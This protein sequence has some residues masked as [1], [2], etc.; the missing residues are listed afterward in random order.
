MRRTFGFGIAV[1]SLVLAFA[2]AHPAQTCPDNYDSYTV[3]GDVNLGWGTEGGDLWH[4]VLKETDTSTA[5]GYDGTYTRGVL[6]RPPTTEDLPNPLNPTNHNWTEVDYL[7]ATGRHGDRALY[8]L[9][10]LDPRFGNQPVSLTANRFG[11]GF[12]L[13]GAGRSIRDVSHIDVVHSFTTI[14]SVPKDVHPYSPMLVVSGAGITPKS[15]GPAD[16]Q[17]MAQVTFDA[18]ASTSNTVGIWTGP[19]LLGVLRASGVNTEDMDSYIVVQATDGYAT[20]VSMYEA[21]QLI[22]N[23]YSLLA[24]KDGLN[25]TI[26]NGSCTDPESANTSCKDGGFVRLVLPKDLAAGRWISNTAQIMVFSLNE[27]RWR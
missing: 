7:L 14:K 27:H 21:T 26:N 9:G 10:E 8:S 18:S 11:R 13:D 5:G 25:N 23:Q 24:T 15:F 20:L 19:T 17:A 22:G 4:N 2:W 6:A 12:S 16:L 1:V 3:T